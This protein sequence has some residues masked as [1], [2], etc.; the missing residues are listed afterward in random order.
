MC[1]CRFVVHVIQKKVVWSLVLTQTVRFV[2]VVLLSNGEL[3]GCRFVVLRSDVWSS[4][5]QQ[6]LKESCVSNKNVVWWSSKGPWW[7]VHRGGERCVEV[8]VCDRRL[9]SKSVVW[10]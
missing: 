9:L 1:D 10:W 4:F 3:C 8:V 2:V 5:V 7:S 6:D